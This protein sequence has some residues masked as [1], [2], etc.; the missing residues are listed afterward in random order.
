MSIN[1]DHFRPNIKPPNPPRPSYEKRSRK[2][3][4]P[5]DPSKGPAASERAS[6]RAGGARPSPPPFLLLLLPR[7]NARPLSSSFSAGVAEARSRGPRNLAPNPR[8]GARKR[9]REEED[10]VGGGGQGKA[11]Y[12]WRPVTSVGAAQHRSCAGCRVCVLL[13]CV[14]R[15]VVCCMLRGSGAEALVGTRLGCLPRAR[16]WLWWGGGV[17]GT[18]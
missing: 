7:T 12:G 16:V 4:Q 14:C 13:C 9:G 18:I 10:E 15:R 2:K 6:E 17:V 11:G 1:L 8:A 3:R 5:A